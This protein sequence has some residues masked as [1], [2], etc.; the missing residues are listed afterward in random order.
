MLNKLK[1]NI[2]KNKKINLNSIKLLEKKYNK[3]KNPSFN[4]HYHNNK[5]INILE[6]VLTLIKIIMINLKEIK[7]VLLIKCGTKSINCD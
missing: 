3:R 6:M 5:W 7:K 1:K 4:L 2:I